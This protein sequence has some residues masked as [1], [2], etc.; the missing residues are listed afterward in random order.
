MAVGEK[1]MHDEVDV[2]GG[3]ELVANAIRNERDPERLLWEVCDTALSVFRC[4]RAWLLF[5]CD[6]DAPSW[7][8]PIERAVPEFPGA[9]LQGSI[10]RMT[11]DVA[12]I[13]RT[14]LD[15]ELP[16]V[17]GPGGRPLAENTRGFDV[18]SQLS[19][20]IFPKVGRPWQFGLHQCSFDRAWKESEIKLFK[21]IGIMA[22]EALGNLLLAR[23]LRTANRTLEESVAARTAELKAEKDFAEGLIEKAQAVVLMLD[24]EGRI[25]RFNSFMEK[26]SGYRLEEVRGRSWLETFVTDTERERVRGVF[27]RVKSGMAADGNINA[28]VTKDGQLRLLEWYSTTL[29]SPRDDVVGI[30]SI[31]HDVTERVAAEE[32]IRASLDE[33]EVLLR[34]I[35]HRVKNNM[36]VVSSLIRI[37]RVKLRGTVDDSILAAF[38]ETEDRIKSMALVHERLYVSDDLAHID[39]ATYITRLAEGLLQSYE[40]RRDVITL[41][42]HVEDVSMN[43]N[44]GVP[45]GL[46]V[47]ELISNALKHAFPDGRQGTV[48][49]AFRCIGDGLHELSVYDDG[50]G[51][52]Q[53]FSL[54]T[55]GTTGM[56]IVKALAGQLGGELEVG[57]SGGASFHIRFMV[58]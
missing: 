32:K 21:I 26:T 3:V 8:V 37:Q 12:E 17:Y 33:K 50:V 38:S 34:E 54:E 36:Q 19:M 39:L 47:N 24:P 14:A 48:G 44:Q 51:L 7:T 56:A 10:V 43:I 30:L 52:P 23:D 41:E 4:D 58:S 6:P 29:R 15:S 35:H 20:A 53:G 55:A 18:R 25:M 46:I 49:V 2:L 57:R 22:A 5:P 28:M 27:L 31:G 13:F 1:K 16:V 40:V 45:C 11:P 42:A 9:Q